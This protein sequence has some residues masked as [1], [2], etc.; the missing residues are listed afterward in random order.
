MFLVS[1]G[2]TTLRILNSFV[3]FY[4]KMRFFYICLCE[5]FEHINLLTSGK[6]ALAPH[7]EFSDVCSVELSWWWN[8]LIS[9]GSLAVLCWGVP[10]CPC[11][12]LLI[13]FPQEWPMISAEWQRLSSRPLWLLLRSTIDYI[14]SFSYWH[15]SEDTVGSAVSSDSSCLCLILAH[16]HEVLLGISELSW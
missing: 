2:N 3:F 14:C 9:L 15:F 4:P 1:V 16:M 10:L 12:H 13:V 7:P 6:T 8:D 11:Q 5:A